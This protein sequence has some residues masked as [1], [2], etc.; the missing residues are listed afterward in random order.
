[1]MARVTYH[2]SNRMSIDW[3]SDGNSWFLNWLGVSADFAMLRSFFSI[4]TPT[5]C[6]AYEELCDLAERMRKST[7]ARVLFEMRD[8]MRRNSS[9]TADG[10]DF[11]TMA[12]LLRPRSLEMIE[13]VKRALESETQPFDTGKVRSLFL[14][15]AARRDIAIMR[16]LVNA[17]SGSDGKINRHLG[18]VNRLFASIDRN[19]DG[20]GYADTTYRNLAL[21][22]RQ[23]CFW[24]PDERKD[25]A[26]I[27]DYVQLLIRGRILLTSRSAWCCYSHRPEVDIVRA[28]SLTIDELVMFCPPMKRRNL[29]SAILPW[30]TDHISLISKAGVFA[31]APEGPQ[32][33]QQYLRSCEQ[34]SDFEIRATMQ[35][36][37]LFASSLNDTQTAWAM[38]QLGVD[39]QVPL[40][41]N[42]KEHYKRNSSRNPMIVAAAAASLETLQLLGGTADLIRFLRSAPVDEIVRPK[43]RFEFY[44][45]KGTELCRLESFR[46]KII[47][48]KIHDSDDAVA[49]G[50]MGDRY[51]SEALEPDPC[52]GS[53][54]VGKRHME[55]ITWIRTIAAAYGMVESLDK[56]IIA[57]A[58][59]I[60]PATRGMKCSHE[61]YHPCDVL[62]L[63][64]LV[65]ANLDYHEGDMDLLQLSIRAECGLKVVELLI[66]KGLRVHSRAARQSGNTMLH[67]ALLSWS[68]DR[69]KIVHLLLREGAE[70]AQSGQGLS[71]LEASLHGV[72]FSK[73]PWYLQKAD[74][75]AIFTYLFEAGAPV[76]HP[77]RQKIEEW[78]PL[79]CRLLDVEA[80]DDLILQVVDAGADLNERG[81][82]CYS[83]FRW[84]QIPLNA[85]IFTGREK[86]ARELIRR[87]ANVHAP[88]GNDRGFTALQAACW[89]GNS[90]EFVDY[91]VR[92]QGANVNEA[93]SEKSGY[94]A[95]QAA[96]EEGSLNL[97]EFLLDNGADVNALSG[98]N[99]HAWLP[100]R[101]RALDYASY[102]GRLDMVEFLL[103]AGGRSGT[104]NLDGAIHAS[105][106]FEC[107]AVRSVL[108]DWKK[109]H[110]LRIVEEEVEWQRQHPDAGRLFLDV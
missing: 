52:L 14:S 48:S 90:L 86:L 57:A 76:R 91:L 44:L 70:Y 2:L 6:A 24:E 87:G 26:T 55:T 51:S 99:E 43:N 82:S 53:L 71:V 5:V 33:V 96:A 93:P 12:V 28:K 23:L 88:A 64:G 49:N 46:R 30:S 29:Y 109:K 73:M 56:A 11:L 80:A 35:E 77:R 60:D 105:K 65:D 97:A 15:A 40:M 10:V 72:N 3:T 9:T 63:D 47:C 100:H 58:L 41:S 94:T 84:D 17:V 37:L 68:H 32:K 75:V 45:S 42:N 13:I 83:G 22:I 20:A 59:F 21:V 102:F 104:G 74:Y 101:C 7:V 69:S 110:G 89:A 8:T 4:K 54:V 61:T 98:K 50:T 106:E 16:L 39:P 18:K 103:K 107:S 38:L 92:V 25:G 19:H 27:A 108:L 31:I 62:M 34:S 67:D 81:R 66:S 36:C 79:I 1:M 78:Q 85:A 95:L